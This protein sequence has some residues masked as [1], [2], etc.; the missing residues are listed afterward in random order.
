MLQSANRRVSLIA[1]FTH[2]LVVFVLLALLTGL[3]GLVTTLQLMAAP[4]DIDHYQELYAIA[5]C[6]I[7]ST[8]LR[9]DMRNVWM[10]LLETQKWRAYKWDGIGSHSFHQAKSRFGFHSSSF[11]GMRSNSGEKAKRFEIRLSKLNLT[12]WLFQRD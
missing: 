8:S 4:A 1:I 11:N 5:A 2:T 9:G 3:A 7:G 6:V 12:L 10:S